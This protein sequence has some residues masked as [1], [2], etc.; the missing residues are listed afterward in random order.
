M[1][2]SSTR[3]PFYDT[4]SSTLRDAA[5]A[6]S[7]LRA[8][9]NSLNKFLTHTRLPLSDLCALDPVLIDQRLSRYIDDLFA[10]R[11]S[12]DYATQA[13]FGLIYRC[14][15]LRPALGE[16][17]MRLRGWQRLKTTRSHPPITWEL[18]V[19][20]AVTMAKWGRH[21][22]AVATLLAF[23]CYLRVGELT[24]LE[25]HDVLQPHDPRMG[26][27]HPIMAIRLAKTKTGLNQSVD[28]GNPHVQAVLHSYL[29]AYPFLERERIFP[30]SPSSFRALLKD[31]GHALGLTTVY[32]PH[33][34]R[35]GGAT[36][37]H[38]RGVSVTD[39]M[40]R[41]RWA[42][43]ESARRYIQTARALLIMRDIPAH[44]DAAGR[45]LSLDLLSVMTL[46]M[47]SVP[48]RRRVRF[49]A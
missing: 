14:P 9:N 17:R 46:L 5:I 24:R 27:V 34:F 4:S 1:M 6:K 41:G 45:G 23:D 11:G 20:V 7:T 15:S 37:D 31:V 43:V 19:V 49:R 10:A 42:S 16:A 3:L 38:L 26:S 40:W 22:E 35:H 8:Y 44:L 21:A 32:V 47:E 12:Y 13:V 18:A 48:L 33:S 36:F 28:L 2:S 39:I 29:S 25:Y 30:F